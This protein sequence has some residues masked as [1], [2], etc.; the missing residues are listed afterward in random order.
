[1]DGKSS[2]KNF[3]LLLCVA[4]A[5]HVF[6][7]CAAFPFFNNVDEPAQFDLVLKYSHGHA[8]RGETATSK[9]ASLYLAILFGAGGRRAKSAAAVDPP[10]G[11]NETGRRHQ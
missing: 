3:V 10:G 1:M 4:A 9:E 7:F 6:V 11:P 2:E 5:I 8:P